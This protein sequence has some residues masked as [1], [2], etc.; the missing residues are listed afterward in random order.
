MGE[1]SKRFKAVLAC[2]ADLNKK[3]LTKLTFDRQIVDKF[4]DKVSL[5]ISP[6]QQ[7]DQKTGSRP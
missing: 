1:A 6:A 5:S 7:P 3:P 2:R 4:V